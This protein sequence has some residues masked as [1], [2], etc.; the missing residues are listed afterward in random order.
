MKSVTVEF[1]LMSLRLTKDKEY[2]LVQSVVCKR[3]DLFG[4]P[5][6]FSCPFFYVAKYFLP[7]SLNIMYKLVNQNAQF[8]LGN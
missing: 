6:C 3:G 8:C 2:S 1:V 7:L 5:D 4:V